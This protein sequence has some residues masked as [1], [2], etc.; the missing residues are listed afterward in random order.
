V[1]RLVCGH[2]RRGKFIQLVDREPVI[3]ARI[4]VGPVAGLQELQRGPDAA[5][6][7]TAGGTP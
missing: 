1:S 7:R 4:L 6:A 3:V 2:A 5:V